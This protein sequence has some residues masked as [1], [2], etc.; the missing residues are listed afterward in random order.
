MAEATMAEIV[1]AVTA[2]LRT[3][4][5]CNVEQY[6][7]A[8]PPTALT[9]YVQPKGDGP[10][11]GLHLP[12]DLLE[13]VTCKR[14]SLSIIIEKPWAD[15]VGGYEGVDTTREAVRGVIVANRDL[16]IAGADS[17]ADGNDDGCTY[18]YAQR[19]GLGARQNWTAFV[20][21]SW[22]V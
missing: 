20:T 6:W 11:T 1:E 14:H 3:A 5:S 4:L 2:L 18:Q 8:E 10:E 7:R 15:G 12:G 21:A 19:P 9:V 16:V 17:P 13:A 22:R